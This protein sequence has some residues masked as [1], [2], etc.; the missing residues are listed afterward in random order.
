MKNLTYLLVSVSFVSFSQDHFENGFE[1]HENGDFYGAIVDYT[2]AIELT[3][4]LLSFLMSVFCL[5]S[6]SIYKSL[7]SWI[8][9]T[10][11]SIVL[12][13]IS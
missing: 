8:A 11:S 4:H 2:K 5:Q 10:K 1:K 12:V 13:G 6:F 9:L 7:F 3:L